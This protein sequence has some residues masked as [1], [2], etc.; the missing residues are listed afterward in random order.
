MNEMITDPLRTSDTTDIMDSGLF[1][2]EKY[3]KSA[4]Q[5]N[6]EINGIAQFHR[7]GVVWWRLGYQTRPQITDII[8][9]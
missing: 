8:S 9:I 2:D 5:M 7:K 4:M 6:V 1:N 3:A